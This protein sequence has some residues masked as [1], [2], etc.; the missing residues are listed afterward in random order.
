M[1][2]PMKYTETDERAARLLELA[3]TLSNAK[4]P[5]TTQKI[6]NLFYPSLSDGAFR[7]A[8]LRDRQ[9]LALCGL[10]ICQCLDPSSGRPVALW[11]VNHTASFVD[12][13]TL[14]SEDAEVLYVACSSLASNPA[15]PFSHD[16]TMALAKVARGFDDLLPM[17]PTRRPRNRN[18]VLAEA[19]RCAVH[20]HIAHVCY[21]P[22]DG[23]QRHV[24]IAIYGFFMFRDNTYY[25]G[26]TF[27]NNAI[28]HNTIHT[29]RIDRVVSI[30]EDMRITYDFPSDFS[31]LE[32][33]SLP[34]CL[35]DR[36][37]DSILYVPPE[38]LPRVQ[39]LVCQYGNFDSTTMLW[40]LPMSDVKTAASWAISYGLIPRS[41]KSLVSSW[42]NLLTE[43]IG[44]ASPQE[45]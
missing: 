6:R 34:F 10:V 37:D 25:V 7:K 2:D 22:A 16:L 32:Y 40:E 9:K 15:Y 33:V 18:T 4:S 8:F 45:S 19:Q 38:T 20:R 36:C 26:A 43:A 5:L 17:L 12:D 28:I 24:D 42:R 13:D 35:G 14:D 21:E 44:H 31:I 23:G 11:H 30:V 39:P 1:P 29:Y 41:P 3:L 27:H